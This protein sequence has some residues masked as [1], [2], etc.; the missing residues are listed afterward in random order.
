[1]RGGQRRQLSRPGFLCLAPHRT[2]T[3]LPFALGRAVRAIGG[4]GSGRRRDASRHGA[5][6]S[7]SLGHGGRPGATEYA[8]VAA[9]RFLSLAPTRVDGTCRPWLR[10]IVSRHRVPGPVGAT[11]VSQA[12]GNPAA[13]AA[14]AAARAR[15]LQLAADHGRG[16]RHRHSASAAVTKIAPAISGA[17]RVIDYRARPFRAGAPRGTR[18]H[19]CLVGTAAAATTRRRAAADARGSASSMSGLRDTQPGVA[20]GARCTRRHRAALF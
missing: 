5:T 17:E 14:P 8:V 1:M 3:P 15:Q 12:G 19:R 7:N 4:R 9:D 20:G 10:C 13:R 16:V 18:G 2:P 6:G 11:R